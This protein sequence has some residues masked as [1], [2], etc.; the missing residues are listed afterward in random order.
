MALATALVLLPF[1]GLQSATAQEVQP[2]PDGSTVIKPIAPITA[3]VD[4]I[5]DDPSAYNGKDVAVVGEIGKVLD[6]RSFSLEDDDLLFDEEMT[7]VSA[8]PLAGSRGLV[9]DLRAL[10]G[11]RALVVGAV[12]PFDV[13]RF[14]ERLGIDLA[15]D[16]F[17]DRTGQPAM[18]ATSIRLDPVVVA[19]AGADPYGPRAYVETPWTEAADAVPGVTID[20]L[21]DHPGA[22]FGHRVTIVGEVGRAIGPR[23]FTV[24]DDD[25]L[26]DEVVGVIGTGPLLDRNGR[27]YSPAALDDVRVMVT[28]TVRSFSRGELERELGLGLRGDGVD[29]WEGQPVIVADS[30]RQLR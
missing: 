16:R 11:R 26:F 30:V 12:Q 2:T 29:A 18:I 22:Y 15:D 7:V 14:E 21:T 19:P 20:A 6:N 5:T 27:P 25:L 9:L 28:G 4:R 23:S 10:T 17:E 1:I 3:T 8:Q 24:E 13:D